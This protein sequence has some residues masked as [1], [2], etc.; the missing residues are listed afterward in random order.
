MHQKELYILSNEGSIEPILPGMAKSAPQ[1]SVRRIIAT[2]LLYARTMLGWSQEQ[3]AE[4]AG[5][6]RT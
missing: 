5:L 1:R 6:H 4:R 2:N 3:L